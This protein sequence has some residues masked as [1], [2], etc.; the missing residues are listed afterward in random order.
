[1]QLQGAL[2]VLPT[3]YEGANSLG[4]GINL[5]LTG[6]GNG[7]HIYEAVVLTP[8]GGSCTAS[9]DH[10]VH[11]YTIPDFTIVA[12]SAHACVGGVVE[13]TPSIAAS[14]DYLMNGQVGNRT[15]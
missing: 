13:L 5:N 1:M 12:S 6:V 15:R 11:V 2:P 8:V 10:N 3:W 4:S 14:S 9:A 7:L